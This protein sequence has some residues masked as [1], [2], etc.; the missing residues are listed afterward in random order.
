MKTCDCCGKET[1]EL[2][3]LNENY[4]TKEIKELCHNCLNEV[5]MVSVNIDKM[6]RKP[7]YNLVKNF[8][9][10]LKNRLKE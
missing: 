6:L 2:N 9:I 10:E 3:T 4:A 1:Q 7:K 8:I 5:M